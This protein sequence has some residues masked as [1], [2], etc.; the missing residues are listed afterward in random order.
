MKRTVA[1]HFL[2]E[3]FNIT[4]NSTAS[5]ERS[6]VEALRLAGRYSYDRHQQQP[7]T[8]CRGPAFGR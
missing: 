7:K 6:A 3:D 8:C 5:Y 1:N 4:P 2:Q